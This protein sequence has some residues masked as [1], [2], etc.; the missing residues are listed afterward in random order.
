MSICVR[1]IKYLEVYKRFLGFMDV[2]EKQDAQ[3]LFSAI[4]KFLAQANLSNIPI[5]AQS[6]EM[7]SK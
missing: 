3:P 7:G 1:Y 5:I 4:I 6:Y 2:S